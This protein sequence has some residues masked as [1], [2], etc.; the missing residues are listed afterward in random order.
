MGGGRRAARRGGEPLMRPPGPL[1][2]AAALGLAAGALF[3]LPAFLSSDSGIDEDPAART[4][5]VT[6]H[7]DWWEIRYLAESP[8]LMVITANELHLAAGER[9]RLRMESSAV[10]RHFRIRHLGG[11]VTVAPEREAVVDLT[12]HRTGVYRGGCTRFCSPRQARMQLLVIVR[13]PATFAEWLER[14][15]ASAPPPQDAM[16]QRGHDAFVGGTCASC[17][18]IRGTPAMAT[19][20]PDLTHIASRR[21]LGAG[22]IPNDRA[23]MAAWILDPHT[24][25]PGSFMPPTHLQPETLHALLYY[26]EQLR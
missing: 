3:V 5:E 17:H 16:A 4:I 7:D 9:V 6:A 2:S 10:M 26:M 24:F 14:Q 23:H 8:H 22:A 11:R 19:F 18:R 1:R 13:E 21:T 20:G 25:K 12:P 15:R